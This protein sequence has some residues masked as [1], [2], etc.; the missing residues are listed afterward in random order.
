MALSKV[1]LIN[2][3]SKADAVEMIHTAVDR[4]LRMTIQVLSNYKVVFPHS[5][6]E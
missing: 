1:T 5:Q 3:V 4:E 6:S 2:H